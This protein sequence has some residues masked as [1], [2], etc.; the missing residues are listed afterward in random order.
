MALA[1]A[2]S[3]CA[4]PARGF[5]WHD[6]SHDRRLAELPGLLLS[7]HLYGGG[8]H[9]HIEGVVRNNGTQWY[10][11]E[12][13]CNTPWSSDLVLRV[14]QGRGG[15]DYPIHPYAH[16]GCDRPDID[17]FGPG[18]ER[19][20]ALDWNG[21]LWD[22]MHGDDLFIRPLPG[23]YE[24]SLRFLAFGPCDP[25]CHGVAQFEVGFTVVVP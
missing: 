17:Q 8:D 2:L 13:G 16:I 3:G 7:G 19:T 11:L 15:N 5:A 24:W 22:N 9:L 10:Q 14:P 4:A 1:G 18:Q 23:A 12:A 21:T 20:F 25:T 6:E